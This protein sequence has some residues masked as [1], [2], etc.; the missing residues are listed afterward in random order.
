M[1]PD[2][3]PTNPLLDAHYWDDRYQ[4]HQTGWDMRQASPPLTTWFRQLADK[5]ISILIPGCGNAYE[6]LFLL[7]NGFSS[8]TL[9]DI[10]EILIARLRATFESRPSPIPT[11]I[12]GDFFNLPDTATY[13]LIVEQ[14][15][16][17][18]LDPSLRDNYVQKMH[19]LLR[20]GGKLI[21]LLFDKNFGGASSLAPS[22]S[23]P[24][25]CSGIPGGPPFGGHQPEYRYLLEKKLTLKTLEPCYNS[26]PP[27]AGSELFFIA[28]KSAR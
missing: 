12:T 9:V 3:I 14:T 20:P 28:E 1:P 8:I 22:R 15:F 26:I 4:Q 10:S 24:S 17:C 11:L 23:F 6:A 25:L 5:N 18:A 13:D 21:G 27:R 16:F 7:D 2:N 19:H